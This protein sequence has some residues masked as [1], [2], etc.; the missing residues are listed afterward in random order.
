MDTS[1]VFDATDEARIAYQLIL[2]LLA[3]M[4]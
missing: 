1:I 3:G 4:D 2:A